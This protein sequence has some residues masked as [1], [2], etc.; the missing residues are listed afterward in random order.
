MKKR[1]GNVN[2]LSVLKYCA[3]FCL[4]LLLNS[5]EKQTFPYAASLLAA[6]LYLGGSIVVCPVLFILSFLAVNAIGLLSS[7]AIAAGINIVCFLLYKKFPYKNTFSAIV[8]SC[9]SLIGFLIFGDTEIFYSTEKR[10]LV[11]LINCALT[12]FCCIAGKA[13][14]EKG[15]KFKYSYEELL[16]VAA[17]T[18][19]FG[20]GVSNLL[21]PVVWK[22]ISVFLILLCCYLFRFGTATFISAI[23]GIS[24][25]V[26]FG[27]AQYVAVTLIYGIAA[28]TFKGLSRYI[29]ALF[30]IVS[31]YLVF[32]VFG[33]YE[34]YT[35]YEY[36][37]IVIGAFC[38]IMIPPLP[39]KTLKEKLSAFR[40]KQLVKET[41]NRNRLMLSNRLYELSGV[42]T[43]MSVA[44]NAFKKS[45]VTEETAKKNIENR[46]TESVCK[47]CK[48]KARCL[49]EQKEILY[50][51]R[52]MIDIGVAKGKVTLIDFPAEMSKTC[53]HPNEIIFG[54]NKMLAEY[55][56]YTINVMNIASGRELIAEEAAGVSEILKG[57]ALESG[58]L[59]KYQNKLERKLADELYK[60]GFFASEILIF[61][62]NER[63]SV[64]MILSVKEFSLKA[65]TDVIVKTVG[66]NMTIAEKNNLTEE[67]I[68]VSFKRAAKFDAVF[69]IAKAVKEGSEISGD[70]HSVIRITDEKFL[71]A[72]SDGMGSG[73]NAENVSSVSLSLIESFY[74]AGMNSDL[75][76]TTVNKLLA[77]NTDD[78]FTA[79]DVSVID[80]KT[81]TAD[82]IKYGSPYGFIINEGR[83]RIVEGN[84]LPLGIVN[85][86]KPS[87]CKTKLNDADMVLLVTDGVSD[88]FGSSGDMVDFIRIVPA[89]NPQSLAEQVLNKAISL[90]N[91][92]RKDDMTALAV[93][94]FKK[95]EPLI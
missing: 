57:L 11:F 12:V 51:L 64:S 63:L 2:Y 53:V 59:L 75:I 86:L 66:F 35:F 43:E 7:A 8:I 38:F 87:V 91:G 20:I 65:L 14:S 81:C 85:D 4:F 24:L 16:S 21:S 28:D 48:F 76:L 18:V 3:V 44:F 67:K 5:L 9:L 89:L 29:S 94:I 27:D 58:A 36:L 80:L 90:N 42:F 83:V 62:E 84:T 78:S 68:Y 22:G 77:I 30:T 6:E 39:L 71:V 41:I 47:T 56:A 32:A 34:A 50:G 55:R 72:L 10:V 70:T 1:L 74:K 33:V 79:L 19:A 26:Y 69:G 46:I 95:S 37:P 25:A 93:R 45:G 88:A 54:L 92:E 17:M 82:F 13:V 73:K 40:E 61:G 15:L 60:N 31:D 23:F 49:K 52:T